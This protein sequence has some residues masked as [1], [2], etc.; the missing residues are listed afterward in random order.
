M[1]RITQRGFFN[2]QRAASAN[3][4]QNGAWQ[5]QPGDM[6][7]WPH[8]ALVDQRIEAGRKEDAKLFC[9]VNAPP[10][11]PPDHAH[12]L[13]DAGELRQVC[14]TL[15]PMLSWQSGLQLKRRAWRQR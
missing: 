2:D 3:E 6:H 13:D 7:I 11:M 12:A 8:A 5:E 14:T 1:L 4:T 15:S 10:I 9:S